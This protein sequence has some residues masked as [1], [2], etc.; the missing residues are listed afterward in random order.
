MRAVTI[1]IITS[2]Q[3]QKGAKFSIATSKECK[4]SL[5]ICSMVLLISSIIF[6]HIQPSYSIF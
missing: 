5:A 2:D 4:P 1:P 3:K 6:N